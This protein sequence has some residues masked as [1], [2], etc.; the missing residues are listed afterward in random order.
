[1]RRRIFFFRTLAG[2]L[3]VSAF[4]TAFFPV[5]IA[6]GEDELKRFI[7]VDEAVEAALKNSSQLAKIN[8]NI[9]ELDSQRS[10]ISKAKKAIED[11]MEQWKNLEGEIK[12]CQAN[13]DSYRQQLNELDPDDAKRAEIKSKLDEEK[14]KL[15][16]LNGQLAAVQGV[17]NSFGITSPDLSKKGEY[18]K[19]IQ[20][21]DFA[22]YELDASIDN[23]SISYKAAENGIEMGVRLLYCTILSLNDTYTFQEK[24]Y[25]SKQKEY[26]AA[27]IKF[28]YG[29]IS[30]IDRLK[31]ENE[32]NKLKLDLDKT[33]RTIENTSMSLKR[34]M[35]ISLTSPI[36]LEP[37]NGSAGNLSGYDSY[38]SK[39]LENRS[40][41]ITA[42][43]NLRVKQKELEITGDYMGESSDDYRKAKLAAHE[44]ELALKE[45][46][47]SV[48]KD[49]KLGYADALK[50]KKAMEIAEQKEKSS[51]QNYESMK[52][53]YEHGY[54]TESGLSDAEAA[55]NNGAAGYITARRDYLEA[56]QKLEFASDIGPQYNNAAAGNTAAYTE[57]N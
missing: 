24:M 53:Y 45:A 12:A 34:Q 36:E 55:Y 30:E 41:I 27:M 25:Q 51:K 26:D 33:K 18:S 31:A 57:G 7:S 23:L 17:L 15:N 52:I 38:L 48:I 5:K 37:Y 11:G 2:I 56:L 19:I 35:G 3:L 1:M 10:G 14:N 16:D 29:Q 54:I 46:Q 32:L 40:E 13:I 22:L 8:L 47:N 4:F 6:F 43:I 49:I 44:N 39:A 42:K 28:K 20:P 21:Y 50:K 9:K